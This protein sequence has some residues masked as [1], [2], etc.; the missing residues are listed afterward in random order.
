M[1]TINILMSMKNDV[2]TDSKDDT[3]DIIKKFLKV[4]KSFLKVFFTYF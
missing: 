4:L 3:F 2:S 1:R